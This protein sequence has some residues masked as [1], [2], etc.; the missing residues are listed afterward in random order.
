[1]ATLFDP[2]IFSIIGVNAALGVGWTITWYQADGVTLATTYSDSAA[3]VPNTN[4]LV[5]DANGRF[6]PIWLSTG[7]YVFVLKDA[8]G[9]TKVTRNPYVVDPAAPT[10]AAALNNFL[11]GTAPLPIANGG[12][13]STSAGDAIVALGGMPTSGGAFTGAI[14]RSTQG[15]FISFVTAAM[16]NGSFYLT[17]SAASDPRTPLPGQIWAR[18]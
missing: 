5:A 6:G 11:A 9:V 7:S 8:S 14:T 17:A 15:A 1:M 12:T 10:V 13:A 18:Y 4:P 16:A 2:G 3:T